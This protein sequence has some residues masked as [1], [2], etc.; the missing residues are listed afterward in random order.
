MEQPG[1]RVFDLDTTAVARTKAT[2]S[3]VACGT[4]EAIYLGEGVTNVPTARQEPGQDPVD[5]PS[6][7]IHR[8]N[9]QLAALNTITTT[10]TQSLDLDSILN[11]TLE[12]ITNLMR[13]PMGTI[14]LLDES[15]GE[16]YLAASRGLPDHALIAISTMRVGEG[17]IGEVIATGE[18]V[19]VADYSSDPRCRHSVPIHYF[20]GVPLKV[21]GKVTGGLVVADYDWRPFDCSEVDLLASIGS[22]IGVAVQNARLYEQMVA[23]SRRL[24]TI[25]RIIRLVT[26]NLDL[27][28][29]CEALAQE[30]SS[31]IQFDRLSV[32]LF[33]NANKE[34]E[35]AAVI[36]PVDTQLGKGAKLHFS[37][38][39]GEWVARHRRP[40]I[41]GDL[42]IVRQ[43][44]ED[45][46]L[47]LEGI[48]SIV[49]VPLFS[50][51]DV[52]GDL[53]LCSNKPNTYGEADIEVLQPIAEGLSIAVQNARLFERNR[54]LYLG[55]IKALAAAIDAKD[56]YTH[57]HSEKVAFYARRIAEEM[58]LDADEMELEAKVHDIGKV[59]ID[60][61]ILNKRAD[62][63]PSERAIVMSHSE[64]GS[65]ILGSVDE[66]R[67]L[68]AAVRNHHEWYDGRGYPDGLKGNEIPLHARVIAVADAFEAMTSDRP[69]RSARGIEAA[70][71]ELRENSGSQFDPEVVACFLRILERD[72]RAKAPYYLELNDRDTAGVDTCHTKGGLPRLQAESLA[73]IRMREV[74]VINRISQETHT[75]VDLPVFLKSVLHMLSEELGYH[76]CS[77]FLIS[78]Q[79]GELVETATTSLVTGVAEESTA[80]E[81]SLPMWVAR[82]GMPEIVRDADEEKSFNLRDD[83]KSQLAVPL[84]GSSGVFGVLSLESPLV[85]CFGN[86]DLQL[87]MAVAGQIS[88]A[89]EVGRLYDEMKRA[90]LEDGLTGVYNHRHFYRRLEEEISRP[91]RNGEPMAIILFDVV[92]LKAIN[93][94]HGHIMGDEVLRRV[95]TALKRA[96]RLSD[97]VARYGGD[98]FVVIMPGANAQT[99]HRATNR[100]AAGLEEMVITLE[101]G[102]SITPRVRSGFAIYP[103]DGLRP[104]ELV[105]VADERM[106]HA[107]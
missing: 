85:D 24:L 44:S 73:S 77:I 49:R 93:D 46:T 102:A 81:G 25:S 89:L 98:E 103:E 15:R 66:L 34:I 101:G 88:S 14:H 82:H 33:D 26:A 27:D 63:T 5:D 36:A 79:T 105:A 87:M 53:S 100:V 41:T 28:H 8:R 52:I 39:S 31:L 76:A 84:S 92:M 37:G 86:Y 78:S 99:A 40:H 42:V 29:V 16:V 61:R 104:S 69:Y 97:V 107:S 55:S 38:T 106:Y 50:D 74:A 2:E 58:G 7:E 57:S 1:R 95:A 90:A 96:V 21:K 67:H 54:R 80:P 83:V 56:A 13:V 23:K 65:L 32:A 47:V 12:K 75:L 68:V 6:Q 19:M 11:G 72:G 20:V 62:L 43:F 30:L 60:E 22:Q 71:Q 91:E 59:G 9:E 64:V 17:V 51:G 94:T 3:G 70:M 35:L 18:P 4:Y 45:E 48:R 10:L